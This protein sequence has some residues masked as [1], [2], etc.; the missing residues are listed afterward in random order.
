MELLVLEPKPRVQLF[1]SNIVT[2]PTSLSR[3]DAEKSSKSFVIT[4]IWLKPNWSQSEIFS[5]PCL[6]SN[7]KLLRRGNQSWLL[8][9]LSSSI[10]SKLSPLCKTSI[11]WEKD[12]WS[13]IKK[14]HY[15]PNI[16]FESTTYNINFQF[17]CT[18]KIIYVSNKL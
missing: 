3:A 15:I 14:I 8:L 1:C 9:F 16:Y 18:I 7:P 17:L 6:L 4:K 2:F 13:K 5:E 11:L 10:S 12:L